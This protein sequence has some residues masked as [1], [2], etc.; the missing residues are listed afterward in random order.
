MKGA[1][2]L[3]ARSSWR[4]RVARRGAI[5][6]QQDAVVSAHVSGGDSRIACNQLR[7]GM[8]LVLARNQ[9]DDRAGAIDRRQR[10]SHAPP[11]PTLRARNAT[12]TLTVDVDFFWRASTDDGLYGAGVNLVRSGQASEARSI[13]SQAALKAE[14]NPTSSW[15]FNV[16]YSRFFAGDFIRESGPGDDVDYAS[17][18]VAY[19]F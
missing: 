13:G 4:R 8:R 12:V 7:E 19:L 11:A 1:R 10:E 3:K 16:V 5:G 17:A 14:W 2:R 18:S 9:P 6:E 15:K